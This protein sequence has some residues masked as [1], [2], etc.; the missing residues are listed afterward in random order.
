M[1]DRNTTPRIAKPMNLRIDGG[2]VFSSPALSTDQAPTPPQ[3]FVANAVAS[4]DTMPPPGEPNVSG[5]ATTDGADSTGISRSAIGVFA[6]GAAELGI[7]RVP[8]APGSSPYDVLQQQ[9][10]FAQPGLAD[11][12]AL[13]DANLAATPSLDRWPFGTRPANPASV[14]YSL[15]PGTEVTVLDAT[16]LGFL[17]QQRSQ[18]QS[19]ERGPAATAR[20]Q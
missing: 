2:G 11:D 10:I 8:L 15:P 4:S 14:V 1:L 20:K 13:L 18:L 9:Q 16:R 12:T 6:P 7:T 3:P 17:E 5:T 19:A